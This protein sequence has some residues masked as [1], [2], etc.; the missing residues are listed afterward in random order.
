MNCKLA[1]EP[2]FGAYC[3]IFPKDLASLSK[4]IKVRLA[5][6][7]KQYSAKFVQ[8]KVVT[9]N[10]FIAKHEKLLS[11]TVAAKLTGHLNLSEDCVLFLAFGDKLQAVRFSNWIL[12]N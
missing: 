12:N 8:Y 1:D 7:S 4:T 10:D 5:E 11:K 2:N 6:I 9:P 3:I